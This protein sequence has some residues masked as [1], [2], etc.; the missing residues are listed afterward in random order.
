MPDLLWL[1]LLPDPVTGLDQPMRGVD[2]CESWLAPDREAARQRILPLLSPR[3]RRLVAI[4]S[5]LEY[6]ARRRSGVKPMAT[7]DPAGE[8]RKRSPGRNPGMRC[9][10]GA[11][12]PSPHANYCHRHR[13]SGRPAGRGR[14]AAATTA[15]PI[16]SDPSRS[17]DDC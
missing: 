17:A 1:A 13:P 5:A 9:W 3:A 4:T 15:L 2:G 7:Y 10:C 11:R 12:T 16:P 14:K 8:G 6:A